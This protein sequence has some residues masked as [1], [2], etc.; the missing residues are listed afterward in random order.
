MSL[1]RGS[2]VEVDCGL[3]FVSPFF[4]RTI[5][6]VLLSFVNINKGYYTILL[7]KIVAHD[8]G[9]LD[10]ELFEFLELI[11]QISPKNS[12]FSKNRSSTVRHILSVRYARY[13][14]SIRGGEVL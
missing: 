6:M 11:F 12:I 8:E 5:F 4:N 13:D 1:P 3:S 7:Y 9:S 10:F 2:S 14:N